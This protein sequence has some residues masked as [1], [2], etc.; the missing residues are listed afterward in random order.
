MK[1][2]LI[3]EKLSHS[4]SASIHGM[5]GSYDYEL[6]EISKEDFPRFMKERSFLAINVTIPYKIDVI[7]YLDFMDEASREIGSV[8][9]VVNK[10]GK[11]YGYNTDFFG[12]KSLIEKL[13]VSVA[14]KKCAI[15][16]TGG[17]SRTAKAVLKA[18]SAGE[19]L[20]VG[21]EKRAG[22]ITYGELYELHSDTEIFINTTP[23]GMFPSV[24]GTPIDI[25]KFKGA[26]AV[27]D[28]VY[29]P[30]KTRLIRDASRLGIAAEGGLYMLVC[31]GV[32]ASEIFFDK[33]YPL[34][35][36]DT[37]YKKIKASRENIILTG[38]PASGKS[39]VGR[40]ISD[41]LS[42]A[43]YDT[44][45]LIE[46]KTGE[47][48]P[49]IFKKYGEEYFRNIESEVIAEI[50]KG[51]SLVIATGGG[52]ILRLKNVDALSQNGR[53]YFIDRP[54]ELLLPTEDRPLSKTKEDIEKRY[55]ERYD[56]YLKC[57]DVRISAEGAPSE[58]AEKIYKDIC[59]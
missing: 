20:L 42:R 6:C 8:N 18:L 41:E 7:P 17:T 35:T 51:T 12:M 37:V 36:F 59:L 38:M 26:R 52:A 54:L 16:G 49:D 55:S 43:F 57:A 14:G 23:L 47:K 1:Y 45:T 46:E 34:D 21:R 4:F 11:L 44:D 48:I 2:G 58:V 39:T 3:G 30:M 50:S 40:L 28:A 27:I 56:T 25:S 9:T 13:G 29:N 10:N 53:I 32:R 15:L 24:E 19:I 31:Q 22:V 33:K 5:L